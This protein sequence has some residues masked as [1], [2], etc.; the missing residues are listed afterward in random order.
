MKTVYNPVSEAEEVADRHLDTRVS[1]IVPGEPQKALASLAAI[2]HPDMGDRSRP[3]D[4]GQYPRLPRI[5]VDAVGVATGCLPR[6]HPSRLAV[7]DDS[8]FIQVHGVN[9]IGSLW[10]VCNFLQVARANF[11]VKKMRYDCNLKEVAHPLSNWLLVLVDA[12]KRDD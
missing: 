11:L 6:G 2:R 4:V 10:Q 3:L 12:E 7:S 1:G 5:G 8:K 9:K